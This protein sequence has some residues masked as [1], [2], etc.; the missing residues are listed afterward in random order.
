MDSFKG[1]TFSPIEHGDY[2]SIIQKEV[3]RQNQGQRF[4]TDQLNENWNTSSRIAGAGLKKF[5]NLSP[6]LAQVA[7]LEVNKEKKRR[8][9]AGIEWY[10][11]NGLPQE[12]LQAFNDAVKESKESFADANKLANE[13]YKKSGDWWSSEGFRKLTNEAQRAALQE[14]FQNRL[15]QYNPSESGIDTATNPAEF[16]GLL[17]S[18][19]QNFN[20]DYGDIDPALLHESLLK[21]Q[22]VKDAELYQAWSTETISGM[23]AANNDKIFSQFDTDIKTSDKPVDVIQDFLLKYESNYD[24]VFQARSAVTARLKHLASNGG[25]N[26]ATLHA[27]AKGTFQAKDGSLP[28]WGKLYKKEFSEILSSVHEYEKRANQEATTTKK[29]KKSEIEDTLEEEWKA[30]IGDPQ[31][32]TEAIANARAALGEVDPQAETTFIDNV[33]AALEANRDGQVTTYLEADFERLEKLNLLF[34]NDVKNRIKG[35][36]EL[37]GWLTK[38]EKQ[39]ENRD[40]GII[41]VEG[42]WTDYVKA[43]GA[44]SKA[45]QDS[46]AEHFGEILAGVNRRLFQKIGSANPTL[47]NEQVGQLAQQKT[48]EFFKA[49]RSKLVRR[50]GWKMDLLYGIESKL[51]DKKGKRNTYLDKYL[52]DVDVAEDIRLRQHVA[53][54]Q[55]DSLGIGY[56]DENGV[57]QNTLLP[58]DEILQ[59]IAQIGNADYRPHPTVTW[60]AKNF[61]TDQ[62][63]IVTELAKSIG[64]EVPQTFRQLKLRENSRAAIRRQLD[65]PSSINAQFGLSLES[66]WIKDEESGKF[67]KNQF[68]HIQDLDIDNIDY[69]PDRL[70]NPFD[71]IQSIP[72]EELEL[73]SPAL[74]DSVLELIETQGFDTEV[75]TMPG[76][77]GYIELMKLW[78]I[79]SNNPDD[80]QAALKNITYEGIKLNQV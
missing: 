71:V 10:Y 5:A 26:R 70:Y 11:E 34:P 54:H 2:A 66:E 73:L 44:G 30:A 61:G 49:N 18:Y 41:W 14:H 63:T 37:D 12:Q 7:Q 76:T 8:A 74:V 43:N 1:G 60:L 27:I 16:H 77:E 13:Y 3:N 17:K 20:A 31:K 19:R 4:V 33:V 29:F 75:L 68:R 25:I 47:S 52:K 67:I 35:F 32:Q 50:N 9:A 51:E 80:K 23:Q 48:E 28:A 46:S 55:W 38:A 42:D 62:H 56:E 72:E 79:K 69:F 57:I 64:E 58:R 65:E 22:R 45:E 21:H 6:Y 53:T 24:N 40:K 78:A 39:Q 36:P 15:A 59:E